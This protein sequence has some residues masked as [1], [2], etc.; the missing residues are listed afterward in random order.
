MIYGSHGTRL[1]RPCGLA[2]SA[3]GRHA[4]LVDMARCLFSESH[5]NGGDPWRS[6]QW[7]W[8]LKI[9]AIWCYTRSFLS[10]CVRKF[11]YKWRSCSI[12]LRL[13]LLQAAFGTNLGNFSASDVFISH[14]L[15]FVFNVFWYLQ[16]LILWCKDLPFFKY[17][18]TQPRTDKAA[19][20]RFLLNDSLQPSHNLHKSFERKKWKEQNWSLRPPAMFSK[21]YF[22]A[23]V[24]FVVGGQREDKQKIDCHYTSVGVASL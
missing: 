15:P 1:R 16:S 13:Q 3:E 5:C 10:H 6:W 8:S 21:G 24:L 22:W 18:D 19:K 9:M 17:S 20:K 14:D 23:C 4:Y 2:V 11:R 12:P 7:W